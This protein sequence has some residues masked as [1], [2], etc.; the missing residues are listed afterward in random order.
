[1]SFPSGHAASAAF[2]FIFFYYYLNMDKNKINNSLFNFIRLSLISI[3]F[4][5]FI[6]C[7][8]TRITDF[9]H[10]PSDV[11]GGAIISVIFYYFFFSSYKI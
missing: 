6:V 4:V 11:I 1:M 9:W 3:I 5:F 7:S 8:I 2:F 10:F